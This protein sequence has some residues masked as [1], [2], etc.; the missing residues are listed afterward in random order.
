[1]YQAAEAGRARVHLV[2]DD[3]AVRDSLKFALELEGLAVQTWESG[4]QLLSDG[5]LSA[6]DCL[7]LDCKMPGLD[8]FA[9]IAALAGRNVKVPII[10]IT[11]PVTDA[12]CRQAVAAGVY[13]VLEKPLLDSILSDTVRRALAH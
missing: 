13:C 6:A 12:V 10:M 7:V 11:A 1:V 2:D 5:D 8:G 9:L 3:R 4:N